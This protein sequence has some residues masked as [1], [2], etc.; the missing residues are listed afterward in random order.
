VKNQ[1]KNNLLP[2]WVEI[3]FVQIGLPDS[4][5]RTFLKQ[6]KIVKQLIDSQTKNTPT[7]LIIIIA[8]AYFFPI[9][10]HASTHNKCVQSSHSIISQ[11][12]GRDKEL[13]NE[14]VNALATNFCNGGSIK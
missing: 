9:V 3:L 12:I 1:P 6:K 10:K 13:T 5:L 11:S 4:W 14:E 7:V 8:I 2:W